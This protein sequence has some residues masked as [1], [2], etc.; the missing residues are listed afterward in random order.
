MPSTPSPP[1]CFPSLSLL[2][3]RRP[4]RRRPFLSELPG[5]REPREPRE[6]LD[7]LDS[8]L[9]PISM[10]PPPPPP[11]ARAPPPPLSVEPPTEPPAPEEI[12]DIS[13]RGGTFTCAARAFHTRSMRSLLGTD[14][15]PNPESAYSDSA[16][17][18]SASESLRAAAAAAAAA[19]RRP[20]RCPLLARCSQGV[21]RSVLVAAEPVV[22]DVQRRERRPREAVVQRGAFAHRLRVEGLYGDVVLHREVLEASVEGFLWM[23]ALVGGW[24]EGCF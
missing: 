22:A 17:A 12:T 1:H 6:P 15:A 5:S 8:D 14:P 13:T 11:A 3:F 23:E 21:Q 19:A 4:E 20:S 2:L 18:D 24:L 9:S 16:W 7:V 10:P